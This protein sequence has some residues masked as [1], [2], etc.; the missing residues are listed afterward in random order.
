MSTRKIESLEAELEALEHER[1]LATNEEDKELYED[2][3]L[4]IRMA[5]EAITGLDFRVWVSLQRQRNQRKESVAVAEDD[6]T[7]EASKA[8]LILN[9]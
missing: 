7:S 8:V 5:I 1:K 3:I 6:K 9:H 2:E 4:A